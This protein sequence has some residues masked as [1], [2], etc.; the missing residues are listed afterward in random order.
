MDSHKHFQSLPPSDMRQSCKSA[1]KSCIKKNGM[2]VYIVMEGENESMSG[3]FPTLGIPIA[4]T[5]F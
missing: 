1:L 5:N 3:G 4:P 2:K